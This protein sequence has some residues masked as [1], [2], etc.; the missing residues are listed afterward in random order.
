VELSAPKPFFSIIV[1]TFR[2]PRALTELLTGLSRQC[3]DSSQMEIIVVDDS[4]ESNLEPVIE[5]FRK[6]LDLKWTGTPHLGPAAARQAGVDLARGKYLAFTDDDCIPDPGWL[7]HL[8]EAVEANPGCAIAGSVLNGLEGNLYAAAWQ[9]IFDYIL[10][11]NA[12]P[13]IEYVGTGNVAFPAD[14]FLE[15]GGLD[16]KWNIWGG[17]DRDLCRRWRASG[18]RFV[19]CPQAMILHCHPLTLRSF[20]NQ[21][22]RYGQGAARFRRTSPPSRQGPGFYTGLLRAGFRGDGRNS[23]FLLGSLVL[24]SQIAIACGF[25]VERLRGK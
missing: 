7:F 16:R 23:S 1:A 24:L 8:R 13:E 22:F 14:A 17:E 11:K 18:R 6:S 4:G 25:Q 20:C 3:F 5:P 10:E 9:I 2:R 15:I 21:Q 19:A 12:T